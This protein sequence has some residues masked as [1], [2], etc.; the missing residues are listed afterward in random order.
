MRNTIARATSSASAIRPRAC[1]LVDILSAV[2]L[3]VMRAVMGVR[4][5]PGATQFTRMLAP[6]YV[7]AAD[8]ASPTIPAFAAAMASWLGSPVWATAEEQRTMDPPLGDCLLITLTAAFTA[9]N[10]L[11]RF[12]LITSLN[13][14]SVVV[15]A[16]LRSTEP[17][18]FT[19]PSTRP[20]VA[21]AFC[22]NASTSLE[23][24][25]STRDTCAWGYAAIRAS[26]FSGFLPPIAS[27]E[28][29]DANCPQ[30]SA[31]MP[32][33][34]PSTTYTGVAVAALANARLQ[35]VCTLVS[36]F[37]APNIVT[38]F[39]LRFNGRVCV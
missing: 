6:A 27:W 31:P 15:C 16:G 33:V 9:Q 4:V 17:T 20:Y 10:A 8:R 35:K 19:T 32:P 29:E 13:S 30:T 12:V 28:P 3:P 23:L 18:Q 14:S 22:I 11:N 2:S 36:G 5:S 7:A 26:N 21:T 25:A 38:R 37:S 24:V 34:A 39:G 1:M